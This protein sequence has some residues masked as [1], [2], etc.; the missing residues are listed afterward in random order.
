MV[1]SNGSGD[2]LG[3]WLLL[4]LAAGAACAGGGLLALSGRWRA[5]YRPVD[6][7]IRYAALA[8]IPFGLG[9][10]VEAAATVLP[11]PVTARQVVAVALLVCLLLSALLFLHYP[12]MLRP[13]WIRDADSQAAGL[14]TGDAVSR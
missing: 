4:M 6:S 9:C 5:W 1:G 14:P 2:A 12:A 10:L 3:T 7:P 8:G 13:G 11:L